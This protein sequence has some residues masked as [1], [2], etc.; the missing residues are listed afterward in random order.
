MHFSVVYPSKS[1]NPILKSGTLNFFSGFTV[2]TPVGLDIYIGSWILKTQSHI[3]QLSH[4]DRGAA[5]VCK[6]AL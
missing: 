1:P 6:F 2:D 4:K 3:K 5:I